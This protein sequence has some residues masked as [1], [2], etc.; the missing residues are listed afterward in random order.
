MIQE[1]QESLY[2]FETDGLIVFTILCVFQSTK[3]DT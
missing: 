3:K 1:S 2:W